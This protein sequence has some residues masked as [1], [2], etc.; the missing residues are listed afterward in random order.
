[1]VRKD[2]VSSVRR[3]NAT[4]TSRARDLAG[5]REQVE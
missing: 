5:N 2:A 3:A 4:M 1:M